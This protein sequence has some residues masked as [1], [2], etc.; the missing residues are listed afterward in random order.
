MGHYSETVNTFVT[1]FS[2]H[3]AATICCRGEKIA[4]LGRRSIDLAE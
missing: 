4:A 3:H 2:P 1:T